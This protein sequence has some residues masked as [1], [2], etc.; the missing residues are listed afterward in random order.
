[1]YGQ[2]SELDN[3]VKTLEET[4]KLK[5][6]YRDAYFALGIFYHELALNAQG[7]VVKPELQKKAE[8]SLN[9]ILKNLNVDDEAAL[10]TLQSWNSQ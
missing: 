2:N 1:M 8:D 9:Y 10:Q 4:I 3:A 7:N 6:D 5:P